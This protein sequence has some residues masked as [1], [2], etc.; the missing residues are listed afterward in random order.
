M[1][2]GTITAVV[3]A[4]SL[5]AIVPSNAADTG[6]IEGVVQFG[7]AKIPV[8]AKI[9]PTTDTTIC[10][11]QGL[12]EESLLV[13]EKTRGV[14]NV[15][16]WVEG[17]KAATPVDDP[18]L[19]NRRCRYEPH[20]LVVAAGDKV[21]IKNRD[22]FL[23]TTQAKL[24]DRPLFNVALPVHNQTVQKRFKKPGRYAVHCDVHPWMRGWVVVMDG[25]IS[26]VSDVQ[27]SFT[28][29]GVPAGSHTIRLWHETLGEASVPVVVKAA[30]TAKTVV[31]LGK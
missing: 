31:K 4:T 26:A 14:M 25:E 22:R 27:G 9:E 13:D 3:L 19:D 11:Q 21:T 24:N 15:V 23:H 17:S 30:E 6:R 20:V 2:C 7:G 18:Q 12:V 5:G 8:P 10:S 1:R 16:A 29:D 28:L